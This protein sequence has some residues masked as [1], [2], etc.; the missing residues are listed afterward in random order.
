M[1]KYKNY[2][3]SINNVWT[4]FIQEV[5]NIKYILFIVFFTI[6]YSIFTIYFINYKSI[7]S[8]IENSDSLLGKI[9]IILML[10]EGI[11]SAFSKLDAI[12]LIF[13]GFLIGINLSL[14]IITAEKLRGSGIK[15]VIGGGSILGIISTGCASCGFS[16]L[17]VLGI[18]TGF[19]NFLPFRNSTFYFFSIG[20]LIFSII[21]MVKKLRDGNSCN[22]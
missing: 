12:L 5:F 17:S 8:I 19:F 2:L 16:V 9:I 18:G 1:K 21:Y 14:L 22:V 6:F 7:I 4:T 3:I 10:L 13:T 11:F 15:F 20:T